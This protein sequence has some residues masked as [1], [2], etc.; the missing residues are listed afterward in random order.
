M[1]HQFSAERANPENLLADFLLAVNTL[2]QAD[3]GQTRNSW[4][5]ESGDSRLTDP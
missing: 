1:S 4:N 5:P 3:G 2:G